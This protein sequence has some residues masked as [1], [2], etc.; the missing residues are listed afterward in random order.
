[1][2]I[3]YGETDALVY[4]AATD[5]PALT[6]FT[7]ARL[8]DLVAG[9][10]SLDL[11]CGTGRTTLRL[12]QAASRIWA[13]DNSAEMLDVF[14]K[15]GVPPNVE[16]VRADFRDL[17][18]LVTEPFEAVYCTLGSL[19][20]CAGLDELK[21]ALKLVAAASL[22]ARFS[23]EFYDGDYYRCIVKEHGDVLPTD[24]PSG[25]HIVTH[26]DLETG[27]RQMQVECTVESGG[28]VVGT[29]SEHVLL[30]PLDE[31][32]AALEA[33]GHQVTS[34]TR[35]GG[36]FIIDGTIAGSTPPEGE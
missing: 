21:Q 11:G 30:L 5:I 27:A 15:K 10:R 25:D 26:F 1:M 33:T 17:P 7:V 32:T 20:C 16:L 3:Q 23:Y 22:S 18:D 28:T 14:R 36:L 12:A 29:L 19:A 13:V 24:L 35:L 2:E 4:D 8:H 9:R 31:L 6:E 34:S